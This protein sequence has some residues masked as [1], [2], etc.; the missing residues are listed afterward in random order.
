ME[1]FE[2]RFTEENNFFKSCIGQTEKEI[3]Q[4]KEE[5]N[6]LKIKN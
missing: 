3:Q 6:P 2:Q 4:V 1:K 5:N